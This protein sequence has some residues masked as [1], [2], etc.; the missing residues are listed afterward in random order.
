M[1]RR[2]FHLISEALTSINSGKGL[3][4]AVPLTELSISEVV[5]RLFSTFLSFPP[6]SVKSVLQP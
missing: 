1:L 5:R 2:M 3:K 4:K 6:W